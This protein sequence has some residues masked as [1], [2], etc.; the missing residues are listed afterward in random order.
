LPKRLGLGTVFFTLA[1]SVTSTATKEAPAPRLSCEEHRVP[2][3]PKGQRIP[4]RGATPGNGM[5]GMHPEHGC[6]VWMRSE[7]APGPV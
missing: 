6:W 4:A 2:F 3:D 7:G 5:L 1:S